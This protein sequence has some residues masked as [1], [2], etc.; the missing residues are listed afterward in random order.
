MD[1]H[2][3]SDFEFVNEDNS[4]K[5]EFKIAEKL[6]HNTQ[7]ELEATPNGFHRY[8]FIGKFTQTRGLSGASSDFLKFPN[9]FGSGH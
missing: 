8:Q 9:I 4:K 1:A 7:I 5:N 3:N 6:I 2:L